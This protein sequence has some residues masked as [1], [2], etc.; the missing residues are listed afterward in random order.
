MS[1]MRT[2][3]PNVAAMRSIRSKRGIPRASSALILPAAMVMGAVVIY[4]ILTTMWLSLTDAPLISLSS[5]SFTGLSNYVDWLSNPE[6]WR[7]LWV[8]LVYT[9]GVTVGSYAIGLATAMLLNVEFPGRA[10]L[11]GLVLLPWAIPEVA[12]V[13]TWNWMLDYQF[14]IVNSLLGS[15]I[16]WV[17]DSAV[18]PWTVTMVTIW[19]QFPLA[20]VVLLA[21][22]QAIP[23]ELYEAS[24]VDGASRLQQF[25]Y[26]TLPGLRPVN[27]VLIM[28]LILYTFKRISIIYL[29][30]GGGPARAT[31]ILPVTTYL[32][33]FKYFRL[34]SAS[35]VG[36]LALLFTLVITLVY[37][38]LFMREEA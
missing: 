8:T 26:V 16:G 35:A 10:I 6:F 36:I 3:S 23:R 28:M 25:I 5:P 19:K 15:R 32:E 38:R 34:G 21:G 12:S 1:R 33:A 14:G 18:A 37:S 24:N 31:E 2:E 11:R 7:S 29:L 17:T 22:L 30:T 27:S 9:F 20:T 4:P 13:M